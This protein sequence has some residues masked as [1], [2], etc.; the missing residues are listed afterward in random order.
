MIYSVLRWTNKNLKGQ[1]HE[2][3]DLGFFRGI[4]F[5]QAPQ[6]PITAV[7]NLFKYLWRYLQLK[8]HHC[9]WPRWQM[10][11]IFNQK[12]TNLSP[13]SLTPVKNS[14][15][16]STTPAIP[17]PKFANPRRWHGWCTLA[18]KISANFKKNVKWSFCYFQGLEVGW[19]VKNLKQ[20]IS[21]HCPF[22]H[23]SRE[24][25]LSWLAR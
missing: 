21:W 16:V 24:Q 11:K 1:C 4:S 9:H 25:H 22:K 14:P 23:I 17:V 10:E 8:V 2:I 3:F 13:A 6:Y 5:L 18:S 20:K 7:S 19:F 12:S 15:T